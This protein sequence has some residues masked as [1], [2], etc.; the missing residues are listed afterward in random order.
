[1]K[2]NKVYIYHSAHPPSRVQR[3][4]VW[5]FAYGTGRRNSNRENGCRHVGHIA[6]HWYPV[7]TSPCQNVPESKRPQV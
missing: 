4:G 2:R 3:I 5:S 1:M 7:K 6:Y